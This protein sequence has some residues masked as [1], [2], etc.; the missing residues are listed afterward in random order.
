MKFDVK[1]L[2]VIIAVIGL[3]YLVKDHITMVFEIAKFL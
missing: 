2:A 1:W 3:I